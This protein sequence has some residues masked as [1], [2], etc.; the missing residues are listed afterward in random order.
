MTNDIS[1]RRFIGI[2][3]SAAGGVALG[4]PDL[5][6]RESPLAIDPGASTSRVVQ[7]QSRHVLD[8]SEVHRTVLAEM[9]EAA[10]AAI[11]RQNTAAKGWRT[12]LKPS[13]IVGI[14]FNRSGQTAIGTTEAVADAIIASIIESGFGPEQIV[15]IECPSTV[16]KLRGTMDARSGFDAQ[17]TNFGSGA[18]QLASVLGQITALI[19]VP[20]LK[21][22]NIAGMTCALKNLSHGFVKHPARYHGNG[23]SPY[24]A[25]IVAL[26]QIRAKLRLC[27]VDALRIVF[28]DGPQAGESTISNEGTILASVD[29]VATDAVGLTILNQIREIKGL[30]PVSASPEKLDYLAAAHRRGL[31]MALLHGIGVT[32]VQSP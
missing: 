26:D 23:C 4:S 11:T 13:D 14:K 2:A 5:G 17:P 24:I 29:P 10:I 1:R 9:V 25:D 7:I 21:T 16:T 20:F 3:A 27:V 12:L 30:P 8:G 22:H 32:R 15:C 31:G 19:N 18:D 28:D 6:Q